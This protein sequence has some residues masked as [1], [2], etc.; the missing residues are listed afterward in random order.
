[1]RRL[2]IA[3]A[4]LII[5]AVIGLTALYVMSRAPLVDAFDNIEAAA[6]QEDNVESVT[7]MSRFHGKATVNIVDVT[8]SEGGMERLFFSG[9]K[10][11]ERLTQQDI[12]PA[13][14]AMNAALERAGHHKAERIRSG[15]ENGR[16][17]YEITLKKDGRLHYYYMS[18]ET[19]DFI[20]RY[21]LSTG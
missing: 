8:V 16:A 3:A 9:G 2:V 20:K 15:Y 19:G 6:L 14:E 11:V 5:L 18:M 21:S 12:F 17:L 10:L 7:G 1:M 13:E 4:G